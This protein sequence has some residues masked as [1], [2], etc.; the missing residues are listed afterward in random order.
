MLTENDI[1]FS[2]EDE[3][4]L[5][6]SVA[7]GEEYKI[8]GV[9]IVIW[10]EN[11]NIEWIRRI[12]TYDWFTQLLSKAVKIECV[13][14]DCSIVRFVDSEGNELE[15]LTT[16]PEFGSVLSSNPTMYFGHA[17]FTKK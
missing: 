13:N 5:I 6:D 7:V 4:A 1:C 11:R 10:D 3:K 9:I 17:T 14:D 16:T 2:D 8:R 15:Q 12:S